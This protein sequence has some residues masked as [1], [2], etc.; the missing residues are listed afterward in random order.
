MK[1]LKLSIAAALLG[2]LSPVLHA[3]DGWRT[4]IAA[5]VRD[6]N[7]EGK[8]VLVEFTG[9]DWCPPCKFMAKNVFSKKSFISAASEDYILVK[10]DFP[11]SDP[12]LA[13]KN[14]KWSDLFK[15]QGYPTVV[16][17]NPE[18]REIDR[19]VGVNHPSVEEFL[20]YLRGNLEG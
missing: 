2:L 1:I 17:L 6:A 15:V 8:H 9:S 4:D 19:I 13:E 20:G 18:G 11:Q 5:A 16:L 10:L 3:A 12:A 7:R 14:S